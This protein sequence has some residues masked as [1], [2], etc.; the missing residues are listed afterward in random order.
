MF[1]QR[2]CFALC[3]I[4]VFA[5]TIFGG[6]AVPPEEYGR[7]LINNHS[8]AAG[9]APVVFDH[10]LHRAMYTCRLCHVDIGFAMEAGAT[11]IKAADNMRGSYCGAC[12]DGRRTYAGKKIF[13][14]C[15]DKFTPEQGKTCD[16]CHSSAKDVSREYAFRTFTAKFP[17]TGPGNDIDWER[18]EDERIIS[19]V[20]I[21]EGFSVKR[22][23]LP[24]PKDFSM[25]SKSTW[26]PEILFSHRKHARWCGCEL[27][28]PEI[29]SIEK[30]GTKFSMLQISGGQYCGVC[31]DRV[32]FALA[33]CRKCHTKTVE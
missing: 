1:F 12:H 10:W 29:F 7:V 22:K 13:A 25:E 15:S 24:V 9:L 30:G 32:A 33:D 14:A 28:H 27:C 23:P 8:R 4:F 21:L 18:A 6:I 19:P 20:D 26:M 16:R 2:L 11:D 3:C 31:H 17:K 5:G